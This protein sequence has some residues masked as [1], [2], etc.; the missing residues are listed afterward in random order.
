MATKW[1]VRKFPPGEGECPNCKIRFRKYDSNYE[2]AT[3]ATPAK[4]RGITRGY[5]VD[6]GFM[7]EKA[8]EWKYS[9]F[10]AFT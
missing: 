8:V 4:R 9:N 1:W 2:I 5:Y 10:L 6:L 7:V 3:K